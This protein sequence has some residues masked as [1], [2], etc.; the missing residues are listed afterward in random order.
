MRRGGAALSGNRGGTVGGVGRLSQCP[1]R[2]R[3]F[4]ARSRRSRSAYQ[5]ARRN[6]FRPQIPAGGTVPDGS[7]YQYTAADFLTLPTLTGIPEVLINRVAP[8]AGLAD[9]AEA[10]MPSGIVHSGYWTGDLTG[11]IETGLRM[12]A[13]R[14]TGIEGDSLETLKWFELQ[15]AQDVIAVEGLYNAERAREQLLG[16]SPSSEVNKPI[17]NPASMAVFALAAPSDKRIYLG[18]SMRALAQQFEACR[19][20]PEPAITSIMGAITLAAAICGGWTPRESSS[21]YMESGW[22]DD[23]EMDGTEGESFGFHSSEWV[24]MPKAAFSCRR[25]T[26]SLRRLVRKLEP[27]ES[28]FSGLY[29]ITWYALQL[30]LALENWSRLFSRNELGANHMAYV[31]YECWPS[32]LIEWSEGKEHDAAACFNDMWLEELHQSEHNEIQWMHVFDATN[33]AA[34]VVAIQTTSALLRIIGKLDRLLRNIDIYAQTTAQSVG[35]PLMRV[36]V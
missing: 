28:T 6:P 31:D 35:K 23:E 1:T 17:F 32:M 25:G 8:S 34:T 2:A 4:R 29:W 13:E 12:F 18:D 14:K 27:L 22:P 19:C 9:L 20:R 7:T 21:R 15:L 33:P 30:C 11:T 16:G 5:E 24:K 10:L 26:T 3:H 36:L